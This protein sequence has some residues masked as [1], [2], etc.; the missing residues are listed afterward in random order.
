MN[1]VDLPGYAWG[2]GVDGLVY[3]AE[4][5]GKKQSTKSAPGYDAV[6]ADEP[7][8]IFTSEALSRAL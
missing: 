8:R 4:A 7:C 2:M 6:E 1:C 5:G 3:L